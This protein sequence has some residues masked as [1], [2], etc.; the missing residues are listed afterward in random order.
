MSYREYFDIDPEYFP[1]VDKK[2][3]ETVP[4]LWKKF[5]PHPSFVSLLKSTVNVLKRKQKLSIWVDGAYGT[6]K[7]H[8][9]L[10]LKRLLEASEI[11]TSQYFEKFKLDDFL[12]KDLMAQKNSGKILVCHRYGSSDISNDSELIVAI[13]EGVEKALAENGIENQARASLRKSLIRYFENEENRKSFDVYADGSYRDLLG[14]DKAEDILRKLKTYEDDSLRALISKI[15]KV[16]TVKGSFSMNTGELCD[17]IREVIDKNNLYSLFFIWD[18]FSE[19]FENNRQHLTGFQQIAD[20]SATAPFCLMI[21]THKAEAYF[22]DGDPDKRKILDRFVPPVH[23]SLPEN[24]AFALMHE[25]MKVTEDENLAEKWDKNKNSLSTRTAGSRKAVIE[26]IGLTDED[27]S[28]VLPIHPYAALLLQHISIYYTS[29]A[30]SMFNFIK[31]DEGE[32]VKAFQWFIDN[33]DFKSTNPFITIDMLW[34]FFYESGQDKLASSIKEILSSYER[35][36]NN[37]ISQEQRILKTILLLQAVSE[38]M[39]GNRDIF[40]PNDKNLT[41]AFEGTDLEIQAKGIAKKLLNDHVVSRTPLTG[42]VFSYCC[43]N[44]GASVDSTPFLEDARKKS[45]KDLMFMQGSELRSVVEFSSGPLKARYCLN[46]ATCL[47]FDGELKKANNPDS[48][49]N[50]IYAV[51]TIAKDENERI[52]LQKKIRDFYAGYTKS[53]VIIIDTSNTIL[54]DSNYNEFVENYAMALAIGSSDVSQRKVYENYAITV[55]KEWSTRIKN[56]DFYVYSKDSIDGDRV[57]NITDL[58]DKLKEIT[59]IRYQKCLEGAYPNVLGTMY[60]SNSLRSGA[61]CGINEETKGTYRSLNEATKLENLLK[62]AWKIPNYWKNSHSYI[63][64]LKKYV[65]KIINDN[66]AEKERVSISSIYDIFKSSPFGFMPCNLTAFILGFILKEYANGEFSYSDDKITDTLDAETLA[67]MI[68]DIIKQEITPNKR[69]IDKYIITLTDSERAFNKATSEVFC[70][71]SKQCVS[72]TSTRARIRAEM[73][74]FLFPI[75]LI[76]YALDGVHFKTNKNDVCNLINC[77]CAIANNQNAGSGK[78]DNDIA[79]EIGNCCL[80]NQNLIDDL[81]SVLTKENCK[82]GMLNYLEEYKNGELYSLSQTIGDGGQYINHLAKK[83]ESSEAA[84]WVWNKDTVHS[85]IDELITEYQIINYSNKILA[86][87]TSYKDTISAWCNKIDQI[88]IAYSVMKNNLDSSKDFFKLLKVLRESGELSEK[89]KFLEQ[90]KSNVDKFKVFMVSQPD[91]FMKSCVHYIEGLTVDDVKILLEDERYNFKCSYIEEPEVYINKVQ[92]SVDLYKSTLEDV[93][94]RNKWKELTGT[95]SP[96]NWSEKYCMPIM[97]MVPE[98]EVDLARTSF[99]VFDSNKKD[100]N[101]IK[102]AKDYLSN[103]SYLDKLN[104]ETERNK[105]FADTFLNEY[106][107]LFDNVEWVKEHLKKHSSEHPYYWMGSKTISNEI[108]SL[109]NS[110]YMETG[111]GQAKKIIDEMSPEIVKEYLKQLIEDN[112]V[113]GIE[114]LKTKNK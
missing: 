55:L 68:E 41:Y 108:K 20:L 4:D 39:T 6:G 38:R 61:L 9:V 76:E 112:V 30:R 31:N 102:N 97:A 51:I 94:L 70:I 63:A 40:L 66:F 92:K 46:Y 17:W 32:D 34:S 1:Q 37:L 103:I 95:E 33:Y 15:F 78:T 12:L 96:F 106:T 36:S 79:L 105:A 101:A 62:D 107:V 91:I 16:R 100:P 52:N 93:Q 21:V 22:S 49:N 111:Y 109:A 74:K 75:W 26:R 24:I 27:L 85:K 23:I 83:F 29:T 64:T 57:S 104:S 19:Y 48:S 65:E 56:G 10:T 77:Y 84:N 25:A 89:E 2:I 72:V 45:T 71:D 43:K 44:T 88:C 47:D 73:A 3:I 86:R 113:V 28:N 90:L 50:K 18:E 82:Q 69:Y 5:Y 114:I 110:K 8:A 14:G 35:L 98:E 54:G 99:L 58:S 42:D 11:E 7:S 67:S 87:N 80:N 13:Q 53:D 81:K 60:D 59:K